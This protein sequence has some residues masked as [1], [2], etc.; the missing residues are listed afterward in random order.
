[1]RD[2]LPEN[3]LLNIEDDHFISIEGITDVNKLFYMHVSTC[4]EE[5]IAFDS[6]SS[7]ENS[8]HSDIE[9]STELN[10]NTIYSKRESSLTMNV[11]VN[12]V[13]VFNSSVV[14]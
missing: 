14:Y 3:C 10:I 11:A 4:Q 2:L 8:E 7:D 6:K 13:K 1:V 5:E 12:L 9:S